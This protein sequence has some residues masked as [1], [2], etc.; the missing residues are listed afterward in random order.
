V[1]N[2]KEPSCVQNHD[3]Q[4]RWLRDK[5][6]TAATCASCGWVLLPAKDDPLDSRGRLLAKLEACRQDGDL[7]TAHYEADNA[8]LEFIN[9]DAITG[10]FNAIEKWYA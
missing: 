8:L 7:E 3:A 4:R 2:D 9:D 10:A 5:G 6:E 1:A